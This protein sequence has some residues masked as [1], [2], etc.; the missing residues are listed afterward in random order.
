MALAK[1]AATPYYDSIKEQRKKASVESEELLRK[2][3]LRV[4]LPS[5]PANV[6]DLLREARHQ[7]EHVVITEKF[8]IP[9]GSK[10]FKRLVSPHWLNDEVINAYLIMIQRRSE[11]NSSKLP[12]VHSF[13]THFYTTLCDRGYEAVQRWT[14]RTDLFAKD[15]VFVPVHLGM[16]WVLSVIDFR[17]KVIRY[18][19]S[20]HGNNEKALRILKNYLEQEHLDKKKAPFDF[21][22]W[23]FTCEKN[24]PAQQ[25]G[26]DC[27]V[28]TCVNAEFLSRNAELSFGQKEML[29]FRDKIAYELL[30]ESLL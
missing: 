30:T 19:D 26:F 10:E 13:N 18:L 27:G 7:P 8:S 15:I 9:I 14:R 5:L 21:N 24:C 16:H 11:E 20:L 28:F 29:Y 22:G 4:S 17:H 25:N 6:K 2:D 1:I 23:T 3:K 12:S